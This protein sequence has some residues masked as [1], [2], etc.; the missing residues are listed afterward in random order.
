MTDSEK[1][2][3]VDLQL[4]NLCK[5]LKGKLSHVT[6]VDSQSRQYKKY[7]IAYNLND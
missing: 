4:K 1:Q 6:C 3:L 5:L 7:I 2:A